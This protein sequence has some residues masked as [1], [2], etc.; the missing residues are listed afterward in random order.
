M[1]SLTGGTSTDV[2]LPIAN[3]HQ[4]GNGNISTLPNTTWG[5]YYTYLAN[6]AMKSGATLGAL[7]YQNM[8]TK[9]GNELVN[10]VIGPGGVPING[11]TSSAVMAVGGPTP[12]APKPLIGQIAQSMPLMAPQ[13]GNIS[14]TGGEGGLGASSATGGT[15]SATA[16]AN[17]TLIFPTNFTPPNMQM[18]Q[19]PNLNPPGFAPLTHSDLPSLIQATSPS[20]Q[21]PQAPSGPVANYSQGGQSSK[22]IAASPWTVKEGD[23]SPLQGGIEKRAEESAPRNSVQNIPISAPSNPDFYGQ[24]IPGGQLASGSMSA[25]GAGYGGEAMPTAQGLYDNEFARKVAQTGD[26]LGSV[27]KTIADIPGKALAAT[28]PEATREMQNMKRFPSPN[29]QP[30]SPAPP[31]F[32]P[33]PLKGGT[34]KKGQAKPLPHAVMPKGAAKKD[35]FHHLIEQ[36]RKETAND[37]VVQLDRAA[38]LRAEAEKIEAKYAPISG[39]DRNSQQYETGQA[40]PGAPQPAPEFNAPHPSQMQQMPEPAPMPTNEQL[41]QATALP[42]NMFKTQQEATQKIYKDANEAIHEL[43]NSPQ[44]VYAKTLQDRAN[45][46]YQRMMQLQ[47]HVDSMQGNQEK[48]QSDADKYARQYVASTKWTQIANAIAGAPVMSGAARYQAAY[49]SYFNRA[50]NE[51]RNT[52]TMIRDELHSLNSQYTSEFTAGNQAMKEID[53]QA[54]QMHTEAQKLAEAQINTTK[55]ASTYEIGQARIANDAANNMRN[56]ATRERGQ[57]VTA[58]GQDIKATTATRGQDLRLEGQREGNQT[59]TAIAS[60]NNETRRYGIDQGTAVK[61]EGNEV[62]RFGIEA[63]TAV[64]NEGIASRERIAGQGNEV[65]R[66]GFKSREAIA[67]EG[68]QTKMGISRQRLAFQDKWHEMNDEDQDL[69]R[70]IRQQHQDLDRM[71][72]IMGP[73]G[74][75]WSKQDQ[76]KVL[77]TAKMQ[78]QQIRNQ[79]QMAQIA[80]EDRRAELAEA[81]ATNKMSEGQA[82]LQLAQDEA[83]F[84][85]QEAILNR[86]GRELAGTVDRL[87]RGAAYVP[88]AIETLKKIQDL[89]P[90]MRILPGR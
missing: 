42:A 68:N 87:G 44:G 83:R 41:G 34:A 43:R 5:D 29:V 82:R 16:S 39:A 35:D 9:L 10:P 59:K 49:N 2:Q 33:P 38:K 75:A 45:Q 70:A 58:R 15:S 47:Q 28:F 61:H 8:A 48:I 66:E 67:H 21:M 50:M 3:I 63:K 26:V 27:G 86:Q 90:A 23:R 52:E 71:K 80:R 60:Q 89:N 19:A 56:N 53:D 7:G 74:A 85:Q 69:D 51:Q 72:A 40:D 24:A 77:D 11:A 54:K 84:R 31:L 18:A 1:V 17:N 62:R 22:E 73:I 4:A 46:T 79:A 25:G 88:T 64:A 57:D 32:T 37:P 65:K 76:G 81:V 20:M 78:A 14:A 12:T 13:Q 55:G 30:S 6:Q 36:A